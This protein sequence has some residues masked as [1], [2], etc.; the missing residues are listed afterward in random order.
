MKITWYGHACMEIEEGGYRVVC[1]PFSPGSVPGMPDVKAVADAVF[2][3][4]GHDD[5]SCAK[6]VEKIS[7]GSEPFRVTEI[8][9]FHDDTEG[10]KRG[11]NTVYV[12]DTPAGLRAVH[13]GDLGHMLSEEALGK[14][15]NP[16]VLMIPVGGFF[17]IDAKTA[18]NLCDRL[19]PRVVIPMHYR[20][21]NFG[22]DVIA[23][24]EDF[25]ALWEPEMI[26]CLPGQTAEITAETKPG[27]WVYTPPTE[28]E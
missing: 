28:T 17:T 20:G 1:D 18:K 12:F 14:I 11:K 2:C 7:S 22:Y 10:S 25:L 19:R 21:K 8:Q 23:P 15:G 5:H 3:S 16:D 4:H 27:V 26:S 13:L 9:T 6:A 24:V